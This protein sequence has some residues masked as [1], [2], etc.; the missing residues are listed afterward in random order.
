MSN[1][2]NK[3]CLNFQLEILT[4]RY[5]VMNSSIKQKKIYIYYKNDQK[6][7]IKCIK[8]HISK[9]NYKEINSMLFKTNVGHT[10]LQSHF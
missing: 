5:I 4:T 7:K 1:Y 10:F 3:K 9:F 6:S 2:I 8:I